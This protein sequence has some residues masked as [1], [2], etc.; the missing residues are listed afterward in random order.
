MVMLVLGTIVGLY[1]LVCVLLFAAQRRMVFPGPKL[2]LRPESGL[3]ELVWVERG[4][5]MLFRKPPANKPVFVFFHGNGEQIADVAWLAD[6]LARVNVGFAAIEYPGYGLAMEQGTPSEAAILE[7]AERGIRHILDKENVPRDQLVLGGQSLGTG[8]AMAMA[9][10]G[11]GARVVLL[12]PFTS[13]PD[14]GAEI[15]PF[16]PVRLLLRDR[17]DS[18]ERARDVNVPVLIVHGVQDELIP[19]EQG[20]ALASRLPNAQLVQI[21]WGGHTNLWSFPETTAA[22]LAFV[23][24]WNPDVPAPR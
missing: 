8:V 16:L 11:F 21:P 23:R 17:F 3:G 5:P 9:A 15:F 7:A 13:L 1:L 6:H 14:V 22:V 10:R 2:G 4:T 19:V 24:G 12:C 20:R 18:A